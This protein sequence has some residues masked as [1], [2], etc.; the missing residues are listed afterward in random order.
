[1]ALVRFDSFANL[2]VPK[3]VQADE[4]ETLD[5]LL[6]YVQRNV[7]FVVS[8][9]IR[10]SSSINNECWILSAVYRGYITKIFWFKP[11]WAHQF[12][13]GKYQIQVGK[14]HET[15]LLKY[16]KGSFLISIFSSSSA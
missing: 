4:I 5:N 12:Q 11:P 7:L 10:L 2:L 1:M 8:N 14:C 15:G 13:D 6:E 3:D 9:I 16:R